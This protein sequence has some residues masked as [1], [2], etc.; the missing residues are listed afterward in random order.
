M[1]F[2]QKKNDRNSRKY[3]YQSFEKLTSRDVVKG[4]G[5][6][7]QPIVYFRHAGFYSN[8]IELNGAW[9]LAIEPTYRFT[10]D[11]FNEYRRSSEM[12]SGIKRLETNQSVRG[13]IGMWKAFLNRGNDLLRQDPLQFNEVEALKLDF[14][15]PDDLW[16]GGEDP[17]EVKDVERAQHELGL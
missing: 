16:R 5:R 8:F 4:Y 7:G 15:V 13:H 12:L 9:Y 14:G 2:L 10:T 17:V 1:F 11:G 6:P 3:A